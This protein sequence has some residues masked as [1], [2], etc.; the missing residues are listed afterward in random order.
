MRALFRSAEYPSAAAYE[1]VHS[2]SLE[3]HGADLASVYYSERIAGDFC[4]FI[5]VAPNRV[6]FGLLDV[7]GG[8]TET[9]PI[10]AAAKH[11]FR[12]VGTELFARRDMNEAD[13]MMELCLQLN[14]VILKTADGV[15]SCPAFAGSYDENLG[16]ICYF[17]AGHTPGLIRDHKGV[18]EL[19]A[20]GLPLGLFSHM[21]SDAPMVALEPGGVLLLASRGIVEGKRKAQEFGLER[22]KEVLEHPREPG[23][24]RLCVTLLDRVR[25]FMGATP[26]RNDMTAVAL[27]RNP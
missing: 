19:P 24:K 21:T 17:N 22:V 26:I 1:A 13:V 7:A 23:A 11:T 20:T 25:Q 9:R 16:I 10:V 12:T 27:A 8:V 14:Q 4:D 6:L 18:S 15:R 5:R 3:V 2:D